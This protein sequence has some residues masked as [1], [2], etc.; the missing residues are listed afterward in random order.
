MRRCSWTNS[1]AS[2]IAPS[3]KYCPNEKFPSISKKVRWWPSRPTSSMSGVRKHFCTVVVSGAGGSSRPRKYGICGCMPAEV[4]SVEWSSARGTRGQDGSRLCPFDAKK[5]RKPS[6]SS[7]EVR[8]KPIVRSA[9][10]AL[11]GAPF[12]RAVGRDLGADLLERPADEA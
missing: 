1:V 10:E 4:S 9:S 8:T 3:L 5:E 6:R 2:S 11:R 7:A 12:G